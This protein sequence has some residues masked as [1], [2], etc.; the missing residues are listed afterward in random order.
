MKGQVW[1]SNWAISMDS[2]QKWSTV[3]GEHQCTDTLGT[4]GWAWHSACA[5]G[6][7]VRNRSIFITKDKCFSSPGMPG[8]WGSIIAN[9]WFPSTRADST[10]LNTSETILMGK[11]SKKGEL[12]RGSLAGVHLKGFWLGR[13]PGYCWWPQESNPRRLVVWASTGCST[14]EG[15]R[16]TGAS[17]IHSQFTDSPATKCEMSFHSI[18]HVHG[19]LLCLSSYFLVNM[20]S[21]PLCFPLV[22]WLSPKS[23]TFKMLTVPSCSTE[24]YTS[25]CRQLQFPCFPIPSLKSAPNF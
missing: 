8:Q 11:S 20:R 7:H 25:H 6:V 9:L 13:N 1:H 23:I 22:G 24:W 14:L 15:T 2:G 12:W 10:V 5:S 16:G 18:P 21:N 19:A 4:H 17:S 3:W